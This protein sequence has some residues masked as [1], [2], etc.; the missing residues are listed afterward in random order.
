MNKPQTI[1][2]LCEFIWY[3]EEKFQLLDYEIDGV[4]VWQYAR[5]KIYSK[6]SESSGIYSQ[7]HTRMSKLDR[8]KS[9][10]RFIINSISDNYFNVK[11]SEIVVFPHSRPVKHQGE[12]IDIYTKYYSD[13]F[14]EKGIKF[15]EIESARY[16]K[17]Y[18]KKNEN[19]F[20]DDWIV[21]ASLFYRN[22]IKVNFSDK[23]LKLIN[24]LEKEIYNMIN[25]KLNLI[26]L[27]KT[28][29]KTFKAYFKIYTKIFKKVNPSQIY[30]VDNY[31]GK[32]PVT[33][34]AKYLGIEVVELQH[35]T[36]GKYHIGYSYPSRKKE[37]DYFPNKLILWSEMWKK[38]TPF[39]LPD[40]KII[41]DK[42]RYLE[43]EKLKYDLNNKEPNSLLVLSQGTI[44]NQMAGKLLDNFKNFKKYQIYFKLHPGEFDRW[45]N[46]P[47]LISLLK[48]YNVK[49]LKNEKPLY[50]LLSKC[51]YQIGVY[52]TALYEGLEFGCKTILMDLPGIEYMDEFIEQYNPEILS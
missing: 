17:H 33:K 49:L 20:Y 13:E 51:E 4:K 1:K 3:L 18:R 6:L 46:Y 12:F 9:L 10:P 7:A 43:K 24:T 48:F 19:I 45:K 22:F 30:I 27:F 32:A 40:D 2:Q 35:G 34:A 23:N 29:I 50:E 8:V 21:L 31:S 44:S 39:P 15:I 52:S 5:F 36:M 14:K 16:G 42:F 38:I 28:R 11:Q 25:I 41:I 26:E 47:N 37:L